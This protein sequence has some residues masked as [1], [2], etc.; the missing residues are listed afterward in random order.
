MVRLSAPPAS[1]PWRSLPLPLSSLSSALFPSYHVILLLGAASR[2]S[3]PDLD[4]RQLRAAGARRRDDGV[5]CED[6]DRVRVVRRTQGK[7]TRTPQPGTS[8]AARLAGC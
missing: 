7:V 6:W 2:Q 5:L 3:D 1:P 8:G 4:Q